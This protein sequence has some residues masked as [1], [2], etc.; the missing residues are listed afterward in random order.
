LLVVK[1]DGGPA[2]RPE[3]GFFD[4]HDVITRRKQGRA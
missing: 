4:A 3:P 1:H 2:H